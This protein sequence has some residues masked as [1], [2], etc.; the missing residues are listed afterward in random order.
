MST[1][2][3]LGLPC[4]TP[5][6][7]LS[8]RSQMAPVSCSPFSGLHLLSLFRELL[9]THAG[10]VETP[11]L[12]TFCSVRI[13][14]NNAQVS[15]FLPFLLRSQHRKVHRR[16][17]V[18]VALRLISRLFPH[19]TLGQFPPNSARRNAGIFSGLTLVNSWLRTPVDSYRRHALTR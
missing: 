6:S 5:A 12:R 15:N 10:C 4:S 8:C 19:T 1:E 17:E 11:S 14:R 18:S 9:K 2:L 7:R 13:R 3:S 16:W